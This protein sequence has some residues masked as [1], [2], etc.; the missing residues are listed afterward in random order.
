MKND[1]SSTPSETGATLLARRQFLV[2]GSAAMAAAAAT[3][4]SADIVRSAL[5]IEDTAPR[6]SVGFTDATLTQFAEP[7]FAPRLTDASKLRS[8]DA[9]LATGVRLKI[10]G[11][12]RPQGSAGEHGTMAMDAM[13]RVAGHQEEIPYMAWSHSRTQHF[14]SSTSARDFVVPVSEG[15]PLSLAVSTSATAATKNA[16]RR[17]TVTLSLGNGRRTN[18]LR[19][20]L[21]FVAVCPAGTKAPD[22]ASVHAVPA[23]TGTLPVLKQFTLTGY[24]P[25]PFDY[26]VVAADRA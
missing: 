11:L 23:A 8:G 9:S 15:Q 22:W 16:T 12:G 13:Y 6:L 19:T 10:H 2:L 18:K 7:S 25:V 4:L 17:G 20:G 14:V 21:Y 1:L 3:S 24:E 5:V 26:I